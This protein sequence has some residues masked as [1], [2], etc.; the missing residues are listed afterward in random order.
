M[1]QSSPGKTHHPNKRMIAMTTLIKL[2]RRKGKAS[3]E[4]VAAEAEADS[5]VK[6]MIMKRESIMI[7]PKVNSRTNHLRN[8]RVKSRR[9]LK[10]NNKRN[11]Q[12]R[13]QMSS[14]TRM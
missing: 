4:A 7:D 5:M 8:T 11:L 2:K 10:V 13:D 9:S 12:R 3:E 14:L 6:M 1:S